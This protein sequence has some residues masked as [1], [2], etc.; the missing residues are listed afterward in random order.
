MVKFVKC[1]L[2]LI[3]SL[4]LLIAANVSAAPFLNVAKEEN[5]TVKQ[6]SQFDAVQY[7]AAQ[8]AHLPSARELAQLST[9]LGSKGIV[10]NCD[11]DNKCFLVVAKNADGSIDSFHFSSAGYQRPTDDFGVS[12]LW[13]SSVN[14]NAS[15]RAFVLSGSGGDLFTDVRSSGY[16]AYCVS[17]R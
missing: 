17:G 12:W 10:D 5:G 4:G 7:C 13:S 16:T 14:L 6:M 3:G 8:G 2:M 15:V 11:S 1:Q 9:S